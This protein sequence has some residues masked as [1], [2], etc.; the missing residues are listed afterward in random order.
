M[1][2]DLEKQED[3]HEAHHVS[4]LFEVKTVSIANDRASTSLKR[5][6]NETRLAQLYYF[7]LL[8]A[9]RLG[10]WLRRVCRQPQFG[11]LHFGGRGPTSVVS[12]LGFRGPVWFRLAREESSLPGSRGIHVFRGGAGI[13]MSRQGVVGR[14]G[15]A[16]LLFGHIRYFRRDGLWIVG[17]G[18]SLQL[19][20]HVRHIARYQYALLLHRRTSGK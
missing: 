3:R 12:M 9:M 11:F 14:G 1:R 6:V 13:R 17:L 2:F 8:L 5:G 15:G 20:N 19:P 7:Q 16:T 18:C 10:C 4:R